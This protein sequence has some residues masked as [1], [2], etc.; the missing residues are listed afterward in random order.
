MPENST[1]ISFQH[2]YIFLI[3]KAI[4]GYSRGGYSYG[5]GEKE[6]KIAMLREMMNEV[7][8]EEERRTINSII[9][10]MEKE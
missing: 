7:G 9:R 5:G 1:F 8:S 4:G 6:E 10:R 3:I 2:G